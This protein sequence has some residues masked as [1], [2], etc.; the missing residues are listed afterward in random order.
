[1]GTA[2]RM[3]GGGG[4]I[5]YIE[6]QRDLGY[7]T[8]TNPTINID[9]TSNIANIPE[10]IKAKLTKD[11]FAILFQF[12]LAG[13]DIQGESNFSAIITEYNPSSHIMTIKKG[14]GYSGNYYYVKIRCYYV[15]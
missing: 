7:A 10:S 4:K 11:N 9:V 1:M 8:W 15:G 12:Y 2:P 14:M 6:F 5:K 13:T 3:P